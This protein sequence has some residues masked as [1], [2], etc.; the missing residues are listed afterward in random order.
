MIVLGCDVSTRAI[1]V[2]ALQLDSD[3]ARWIHVPLGKG[4][5]L[6]RVRRI[7]RSVLE[8]GPIGLDPF[9]PHVLAVGV[10]RPAGKHGV[11]QVS[12]AVGGLL[13]CFPPDML[14]T[15]WMPAEWRKACGM[16]GNA[17]KGHV[18]QWA[19]GRRIAQTITVMAGHRVYDE[20]D[21]WPQDAT[22]A[23]CI[24]WATRQ[25]LRREEAA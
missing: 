1:D 4:D 21:A 24:A 6:E 15:W 23:Y 5:L 13:Q 9:P 14:V 10:E 7:R 20:I 11:W 25:A 16:P 3:E 22:D 2:V 12:M 8:L 17:S 19:V 18:K